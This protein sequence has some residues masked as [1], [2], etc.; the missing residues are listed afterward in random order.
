MG[1]DIYVDGECAARLGSSSAWDAA[2]TFIENNTP[3]NTPLR[4]LAELGDTHRPQQAAA[5]LS[6]LLEQRKPAPDIAHILRHLHRLL[7]RANHLL[8]TDGVNDAS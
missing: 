2:A 4:R 1:Y 7:K 5:M 8:I 3:A 6:D